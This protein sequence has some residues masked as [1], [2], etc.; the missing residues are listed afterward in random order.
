[1]FARAA[2]L[3]AAASLMA[4]CQPPAGRSADAPPLQTVESVELDRYLGR[5]FEIAR[6]D[7]GFERGCAGVTADYA[8][9]EDG[10]IDV[11]NTCYQGGLDGEVEVAN[12]RARIADEAT[13][14]QLEVSFFGPFWGDYW[15][16]DLADDYSWAIVSEPQGRY[17]WILSRT[18]QMDEAVLSQRLAWLEAEG[19]DTSMLI[20]V[21]Q[22]ENVEDVRG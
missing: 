9:R 21:E 2:L 8:R 1:M 4:A 13:N 17:L 22:W 16:I 3:I 12:G 15:I 19:F 6:Y 10:L 11:T 14:A 20:R 7:H 5:W 18:P